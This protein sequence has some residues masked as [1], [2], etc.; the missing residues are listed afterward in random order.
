MLF[1]ILFS[2]A[3]EKHVKAI[4]TKTA[5][6][7]ISS[8][9]IKEFSVLLPPISE[10]IKIAA[11]LSTWD[12]AIETV[13][14]L[15]SNSQQQKKALIQ[16]LFTIKKRFTKFKK[17]WKKVCIKQ[18]G[19]ISSGGT[20]DTLESKYW[21]GDLLWTT[22]TDITSLKSRYIEN[23][24]RKITINGVNN[25][26]ARLLPIGSLLVC[27]RATIG[28]LAIS[29]KEITTNQGFKSLI[30]NKEYSVEFLYY[31]FNYFRHQFVRYSCGS[32][33]LE[34]SKKDFE[35]Q[36]FSVPDELNEQIK[37]SNIFISIDSENENLQA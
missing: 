4:Q 16:Q 34:L 2:S 19:E 5:V 33:F 30:P 29:K 13:E 20:P 21:N 7:H 17:N 26:A 31:L 8:H 28:Y 14:K 25:S 32:T 15:I 24:A 37:I 12:K 22:P 27:T 11:I 1:H 18:M 9:H 10:Q 23:T 35:K 36:S 3:F 6:P